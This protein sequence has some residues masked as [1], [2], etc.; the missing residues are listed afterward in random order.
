MSSL[1]LTVLGSG[2]SMGVPTLGCHC[3]VCDSTDPRDKRLR[4]SV[5]L[6]REG[7]NV[8]IDTTPDF[9]YQALR[10]K[11]DRLDAV[12]FT[13]GHADHIMGLDDIR[14][15]NLKQRGAVPIYAT[16]DTLKILRR[17][18]AYIFE[19]VLPESTVPLIELRTIGGPFTVEGIDIIPIP[20]MHGS[21]PVLGFRFG[22]A[23]YLTDFSFVPDSSKVLLESLDEF[24]LD[25][26]RYVPHPTHSTVDQSLALVRELRPKRAWFTHMCHDL[27]HAATNAKLPENVQLAYDGLQFEVEL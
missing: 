26:L 25:A 1:R 21:L 18:F 13:H 5:L 8:V 24:I 10:A 14:P 2:T 11:V 19:D 17:Q 22:K 15:Y 3:R 7:R 4:P 20:A 23:A 16:T 9:R 6:S 12:I 27:S